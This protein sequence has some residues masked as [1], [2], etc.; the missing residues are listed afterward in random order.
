MLVGKRR[1]GRTLLER[2][3]VYD[4]TEDSSPIGF[5]EYSAD[6]DRIKIRGQRYSIVS[7]RKPMTLLEQVAKLLTWRWKDVF[8]LR[9]AV[10]HIRE[11]RF[12]HVFASPWGSRVLDSATGQGL[13]GGL[14]AA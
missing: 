3:I 10:G 4:L 14:P 1:L 2:H 5:I 13:P 11:E 7:E 12:E 9:D 8:A 6:R